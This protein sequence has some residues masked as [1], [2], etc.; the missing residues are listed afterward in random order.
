MVLN[1]PKSKVRHKKPSNQ[2][3]QDTLEYLYSLGIYRDWVQKQKTEEGIIRQTQITEK[4]VEAEANGRVGGRSSKR[5][6]TSIGN[7]AILSESEEITQ[8]WLGN[9][10]SEGGKKK[11]SRRNRKNKRRAFY[12]T[13]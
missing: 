11:Q 6:Y 12:N 4:E 5:L 9:D 8:R 7:E 13:G 3:I 10:I 2:N 1:N